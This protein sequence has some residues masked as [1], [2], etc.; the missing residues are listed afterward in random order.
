MSKCLIRYMCLIIIAMAWATVSYYSGVMGQGGAKPQKP[1]PAMLPELIELAKDPTPFDVNFQGKGE[2]LGRAVIAFSQSFRQ[3]N[4]GLAERILREFYDEQAGLNGEWLYIV[5]YFL[6]PEVKRNWDDSLVQLL[7]S[8]DSDAQAFAEA[9]LTHFINPE[10]YVPP[11]R[12]QDF[13]VYTRHLR[14][15]TKQ[16][17]LPSARFI[18]FLFRLD[19]QLALQVLLQSS[20]EYQ[21]LP[22]NV[23]EEHMLEF[24][25]LVHVTDVLRDRAQMGR[26][27]EGDCKIAQEQ[28]KWL[29]LTYPL[30]WAK[31]YALE[32]LL[33]CP[34]L[35][36]E[37]LLSILRDEKHPFV[38]KHLEKLEKKLKASNH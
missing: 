27:Q 22:S 36:D 3:R 13:N 11:I 35:A 24:D 23:Q 14:S 6:R 17:R 10:I 1:Q 15:L 32:T 34:Q 33:D 21:A 37:L 20:K 8:D 19:L 26:L 31:R 16:G 30:W 9:A 28:L 38:S 4:V 7:H 18:D 12:N 29:L 2:Q 25:W 5:L